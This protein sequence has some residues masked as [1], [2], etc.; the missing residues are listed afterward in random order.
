MRQAHPG[1]LEADSERLAVDGKS[2]ILVAIDGLPAAVVGVADTIKSG[3]AAAVAALQARGIEVV[4]A[5]LP[6]GAFAARAPTFLA[7][8]LRLIDLSADFR[9]DGSSCRPRSFAGLLKVVHTTNAGRFQST[10]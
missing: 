9:S 1:P 7:A 6:H 4:F 3:S 2:P 8:G 5:C 10:H